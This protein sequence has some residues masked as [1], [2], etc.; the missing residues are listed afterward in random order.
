MSGLNDSGLQKPLHLI[1]PQYEN[2]QSSINVGRVFDD[3]ATIQ[4]ASITTNAALLQPVLKNHNHMIVKNP[5]LQQ[6]SLFNNSCGSITQF[7]Q[8]RAQTP[9]ISTIDI[10]KI[11]NRSAN[12]NPQAGLP[13]PTFKQ[14]E[15]PTL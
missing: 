13:T 2:P 14:T 12:L 7:N 4:Q 6:K 5:I 11:D 8:T 3:L 9:Q 1:Q 15:K 10:T